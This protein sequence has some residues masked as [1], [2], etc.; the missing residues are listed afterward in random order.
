MPFQSVPDTAEVIA[1]FEYEGRQSIC[2]FYAR[3]TGTYDLAD[4]TDLA[5]AVDAA[6]AA[7]IAPQMTEAQSY[8]GVTA[9]GLEFENDQ[10]VFVG[11]PTSGSAAVSALPPNA[12][13]AI[14]RLSGLTGRSARGRIFVPF[15]NQS[16][17]Q[18]DR[19]FV[20]S[21]FANNWVALL[22]DVNAAMVSEGWT[23]VIVSRF[24]GGVKR[25][26]GATFPIINWAV[27][28]LNVDSQRR[29]LKPD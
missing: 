27:R 6:I 11:T 5:T 4:L 13:L 10:A 28:D 3:F 24:T 1:T 25:A 15:L 16:A 8:I 18:T 2:T 21:T 23:P 19:N 14:Q 29:R 7:G 12:S 20:T 26:F 17:M 22:D 9:R